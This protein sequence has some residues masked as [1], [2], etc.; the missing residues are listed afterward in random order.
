M[1]SFLFGERNRQNDMGDGRE[2]RIVRVVGRRH[3]GPL[4]I[5]VSGL[6]SRDPA[7]DSAEE[8]EKQK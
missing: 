1:D 8:P 6:A 3:D 7:L 5:T 2:E 4:V